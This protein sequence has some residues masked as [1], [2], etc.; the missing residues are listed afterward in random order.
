MT[1]DPPFEDELGDV[2]EKALRL[3][4]LTEDDLAEAT[5]IEVGRIKD[6]LDY[7]Y[8]LTAGELAGLAK[9]LGLNEIGLQALAEGRYPLPSPT[10]LPYCLHVISMPYGVGVVNAYVVCRC[11][12]DH[13]LLFDSGVSPRAMD[14]AWPPSL[15]SITALFITHWDSDHAGASRDIRR[16]HPGVRVFAPEPGPIGA[17]VVREGEVLEIDGFSVRV[18]STAGHCRFHNSYLVSS[19]TCRAGP[20]LIAGDT[21]FAGSVAAG[22]FDRRLLLGEVRRL[23]RDLPGDAVVAPGHGPLTSIAAEREFN[24]FAS[25]DGER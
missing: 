18:F 22:L 9:V 3:R 24:P 17:Q 4:D 6:A 5:G 1:Q 23:W 11:G 21:F 8:D 7:R 16:R 25:E 12:A 14:R 19:M 2:L 20:L 15:E 13:G 10:C